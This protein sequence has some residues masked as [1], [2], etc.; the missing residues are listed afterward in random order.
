MS[1]WIVPE[2]IENEVNVPQMMKAVL[3]RTFE[4]MMRPKSDAANFNAPWIIAWCSIDIGV[5]VSSDANCPKKITF[6]IMFFLDNS[7]G[8]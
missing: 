1:S 7:P 5:L 8:T 3:L 4:K 2:A 6:D